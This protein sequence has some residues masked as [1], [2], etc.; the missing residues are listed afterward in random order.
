MAKRVVTKIGDV[1]CAEIENEYKCYFQYIEKD[2]ECLNSSVIR[3][4]KTR[5]PMESNPDMDDI[6]KDDVLFYAH[7]VLRAGIDFNTWYKVGKSKELGLDGLSEVLWGIA[8]YHKAYFKDRVPIVEEVNPL[9]NWE[10]WY[11]NGTAVNIGV[12]P[13]KYYEKVENGGVLYY[14]AY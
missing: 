11:T 1:F 7:T 3:V 9:E 13:E 8:H 6:V 10:I 2:L 5:Y 14:G 12:L 4:F